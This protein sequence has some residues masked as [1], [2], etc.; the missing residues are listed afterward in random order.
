MGLI[1]VRE[2]DF[3]RDFNAME[4]KP[5]ITMTS[6]TILLSGYL[7]GYEIIIEK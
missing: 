6:S 7:K 2:R 3:P 5:A 1:R 4:L